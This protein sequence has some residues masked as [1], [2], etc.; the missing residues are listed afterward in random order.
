[1]FAAL[2]A[3]AAQR[4]NVPENWIKAVIAVESN[5]DPRAYREEPQISDSSY[6][7]MQLL[8]ETARGLG[9]TG[10]V[11]QLYDPA[12]NI[13]LGTNLLAELRSRYGENFRRV[14]S[15]YNSGRPDLWETSAQ[16]RKNVERAVEAL[17]FLD[18]PIENPTPIESAIEP[19]PLGL[20]LLAALA[21][22]FLFKGR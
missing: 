22:A 12:T 2:I 4:W 6:G 19:A 18:D 9:F 21:V 13:D 3:D 8:E 1:M 17:M 5:G 16:V 11:E 15:A 14:Y 10:K 20:L 7:L